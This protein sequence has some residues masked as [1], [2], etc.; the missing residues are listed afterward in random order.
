MAR[1]AAKAGLGVEDSTLRALVQRLGARAE[2][3]TQSRLQTAPIEKSPARPPTPLAV[4]MLD[5]FPVRF[6]GP[7]RGRK[8]TAQPRVEWHEEKR[9]VFYRHEQAVGSKRGQ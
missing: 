3:Q 8:K 2:A 1:L 7:G 6:R 5:G 4:L 9:G